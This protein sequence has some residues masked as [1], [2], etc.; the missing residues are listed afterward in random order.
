MYL[1]N[2][3]TMKLTKTRHR[4]ISDRLSQKIAQ[5]ILKIQSKIADYLNERASECP[6]KKLLLCLLCFCGLF[7]AYCL[8]LLL[9][10]II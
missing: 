6:S 3:D 4:E 9:Q 5:R 2:P 10:A 7:G 1:K 8:Y